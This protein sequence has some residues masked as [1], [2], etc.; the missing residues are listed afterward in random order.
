[1]NMDSQAR[2]RRIADEDAAATL[3]VL[4]LLSAADPDD[5]GRMRSAWGDPAHRLRIA[6]SGPGGWWRSGL[7]S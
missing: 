5:P 4:A 7:P 3:A 6:T 1:M 2:A